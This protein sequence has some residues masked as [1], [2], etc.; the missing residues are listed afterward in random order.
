MKLLREIHQEP[1]SPRHLQN[2]AY[3]ARAQSIIEPLVPQHPELRWLYDHEAIWQGKRHS[4]QQTIMQE[5]GRIPVD[6]LLVALAIRLCE[7]RPKSREAVKM[8]RRA[9]LD[10]GAK[11]S[12][13]DLTEVLR[14]TINDYLRWRPDLT[15]T[16]A[17][18]ALGQLWQRLDDQLTNDQSQ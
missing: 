12:I 14:R 18:A 2:T 15:L 8:L 5:L 9:R 6:G 7:L 16:D 4:Y 17:Q 13:E 11:G 10:H 3:Q 1:R